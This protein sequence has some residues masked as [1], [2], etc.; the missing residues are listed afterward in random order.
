MAVYCDFSA[1]EFVNDVILMEF[2]HDVETY[3]D[4]S[5]SYSGAG[6]YTVSLTYDYASV[7]AL[8]VLAQNV[9]RCE[10]KLNISC[11]D[12]KIWNSGT[13]YTWWEDA[14]GA[15]MTSFPGA[16]AA[17]TGCFCGQNQNC[18]PSDGSVLCNCD[19]AYIGKEGGY[20]T[21]AAVL[22]ISALKM[23]G[24]TT[25]EATASHSIG[26][27]RCYD[28]DTSTIPT[29]CLDAN[30][31]YGHTQTGYYLLDP[32]G[33]S[34]S[35]LPVKVYCDMD[36][37]ENAVMTVFEHDITEF[38]VVKITGSGNYG[39]DVNYNGLSLEQVASLM[40]GAVR[41]EQYI[42][43]SCYK[44]TRI[45]K[46][47]RAWW[48][49]RDGTKQTYW[50]G[51]EGNSDKCLCGVLDVCLASEG[52]NCDSQDTLNLLGDHGYLT[53]MSALPVSQV[54][55]ADTGGQKEATFSLGSLRCY[56]QTAAVIWPSCYHVLTFDTTVDGDYLID[57]DNPNNG[58]D[59]FRVTCDMDFNSTHAS[60]TFDHD[61]E[62]RTQ[63]TGFTT[64]G[65][66]ARD[67]SYYA[68]WDQFAALF[69]LGN[70]QDCE[71]YI[72]Y[73]C[74]AAKLLDSDTSWWV[75]RTGTTMRHW[76]GAVDGDASCACGLTGS[77]AGG[78]VCNCDQ[79][80]GSW[81][82][83]SGDLVDKTHLPVAQLRIGSDSGEVY[84]TLGKLVCYIAAGKYLQ[85]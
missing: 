60:Q 51:A 8:S 27:L 53:D 10:Q 45:R 35:M 25:S 55:M 33:S 22:P 42:S 34:G 19:R 63:V 39:V 9:L 50:G 71:Q 75:S 30:E 5:G 12:I 11:D 32:D 1:T 77:C 14:S 24:F 54:R 18:D 82:T 43:F 61:A 7:S 15:Q 73:D 64:A 46:S 68:S 28:A 20:I 47:D 6:S 40:S 48:S 69:A 16:D 65:G 58:L 21:D 31:N 13:Q 67:I 37:V 74:N 76:G 66:Y 29:S 52:C 80:A 59:P 41:C 78:G 81:D 23:G 4:V 62:D 84:Y 57:P 36:G 2:G 3:T 79:G 85:H 49:G 83:D 56:H 72:E 17:D 38:T 70:V 44:G 26:K